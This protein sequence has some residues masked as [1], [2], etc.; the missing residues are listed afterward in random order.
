VTVADNNTSAQSNGAD[1][2]E[3]PEPYHRPLR[4]VPEL[5]G[6]SSVS[7]LVRKLTAHGASALA[8]QAIAEAVTNPEAVALLLDAPRKH[9]VPG[10]D[11]LYV[12]ADAYTARLIADPTNPRIGTMLPYPMAV[13]PGSDERARFAP[14]GDARAAGSLEVELEVESLDVLAWHL[15]RAMTETIRQNTPRPSIANHGV[16]EAALAVAT[17]I[18]EPDG[19]ATGLLMVREGSSRLSHAQRILGVSARDALVGNTAAAQRTLIAELNA[20]AN[21]SASVV[22][23]EQAARVRVATIPVEI[24]I[25]VEPDPGR[26]LSIHDAV[27]AK[28]GQDHLNHKKQWD[29][30]AKD[31]L[32]GDRVL[33]VLRDAGDIGV[34][35]YLWL[36]GRLTK[37]QIADAGLPAHSDDRWAELVYIVTTRRGPT[38]RLVR[39]AIATFLEQE[40]VGG[41]ASQIKGSKLPLAVSVAMRERR[42]L[43]TESSVDR[44]SKVLMNALP[45]EVWTKP[46]APTAYT[47]EQLRDAAIED[48]KTRTVSTS[49][50]ELL[51]RAAWYL[52]LNGQIAMP[53]NDQGAGGDRRLPHEL[54]LEMLQSEHGVN[55][56]HRAIVDG[57]RG[58]RVSQVTPSG[59]VDRSAVGN[60]VEVG[61]TF[62]RE[63]VAPRTG[64]PA[65]PPR[66]PT[67]EYLDAISAYRRA[68]HGATQADELLRSI[69][70]GYGGI[71]V[72]QRGLDRD[73]VEEFRAVL[74]TLETN[75]GDYDL[76]RERAAARAEV[77]GEAGAG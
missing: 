43:D 45:P 6:R 48:A 19:N 41:T 1:V 61:D 5:P 40:G 42:G 52:G 4:L 35:K 64:P 8:A 14:V 11:L 71:V 12:P 27:A 37:Q 9:R 62:I 2:E 58:S 20:I 26:S 34:S 54:L 55:Q 44:F 46:W 77:R 16:M 74:N 57:R 21:S 33:V 23:D 25:G 73:I 53:R 68:L 49:G 59:D 67:E 63:V 65:P 10:G 28:V 50:V 32:L 56:L 36:S 75:I 30:P 13:P 29:E 24:V 70:D 31:V 60:A 7:K 38:A 69:D 66:N 15:D 3:V 39:E 22:T 76:A 17:V 51:V 47:V 72:S 18:K